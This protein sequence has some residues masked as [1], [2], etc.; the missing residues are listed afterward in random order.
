MNRT[1]EGCLDR[2][3]YHPT[4]NYVNFMLRDDSK[5]YKMF[6]PSHL[7]DISMVEL[8]QPGDMI[9]VVASEPNWAEMDSTIS[10]WENLR[11]S[12]I[13]KNGY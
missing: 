3:F 2:F 6:L 1:I 13:F 7:L 9:K 10:S 11:L 12:F 8:S 5:A 4:K